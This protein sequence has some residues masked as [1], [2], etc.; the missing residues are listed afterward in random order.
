VI[1]VADTS[2]LNYL[3]LIAEVDVLA[4]LYTS[5]VV[6]HSV[7]AELSE[8]RTPALVRTWIAQ[9]PA[10]LA[11]APDPPPDETLTALDPG[12]RAAIAL[13][14]SLHASRLLIDDADGRAEAER[15]SLQVTGTLG[16]L[17]AAHQRGMLD[18]D[19]AVERLSSTSFYVSPRLLA[20]A[21]RLIY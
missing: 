15:R 12:E 10:W 11:I 6:P 3:I 17:A 13:A 20:T 8:F 16:V 1:V 7:A 9:P 4:P 19:K 2:P 18:F 21:R 14:V 5:V